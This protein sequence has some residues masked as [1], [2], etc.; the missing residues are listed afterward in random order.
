MEQNYISD[1]TFEKDSFLKVL[2]PNTEFDTCSF[3]A[4]DFTGQ[5]LSNIRFVNCI[6]KHC[7][8]SALQWENTALRDVRFSDCKMLAAR[9]DRCNQF[10]LAFSFNTC[11]LDHSSFF[12]T[13]IK[14][15][16]FENTRLRDC[17]FSEAD[18]SGSVFDNCDLD[19]AIFD[20][21]KL[22]KCDFH[23]SYNYVIDPENNQLKGARFS[24]NGLVGLL[25]KYQI[26]ID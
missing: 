25:Q 8:L 17:D 20:H 2:R 15:T 23:S 13:Q 12:K 7:N 10:G 24:L 18:L 19:S 22:L 14:K 11:Q 21:S 6:F 1:Q 3:N 26:R 4:C 5:A 16:R 9:F